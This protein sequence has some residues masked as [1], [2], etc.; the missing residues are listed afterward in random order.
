MGH[1]QVTGSAEPR[2]AWVPSLG[3]PAATRPPTLPAL[4]AS[5][6]VGRAAVAPGPGLPRPRRAGGRGH[7]ALRLGQGHPALRHGQGHPALRL[8]RRLPLL[9]LGH[10]PAVRRPAVPR[11][12]APGHPRPLPRGSAPGASR[13]PSLAPPP[14]AGGPAVPR[15]V[16]MPRTRPCAAVGPR[17]PQLPAAAQR[18]SSRIPVRLG[19]AAETAAP[20][21]RTCPASG[22]TCV[23]FRGNKS[24]VAGVCRCSP[25]RSF[26]LL[27][28]AKL[29]DGNSGGR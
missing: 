14:R 6:P 24:H 17:Q 29:R 18:L 5:L 19:P 26:H 7:P 11:A 2:H 21:K 22:A 10:G 1:A 16:G 28:G 8:G 3:H 13:G 20:G 9:G 23:E 4:P 27:F 25:F 15:G 12:R